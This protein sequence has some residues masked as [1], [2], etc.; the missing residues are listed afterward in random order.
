V[1]VE[2]PLSLHDDRQSLYVP[3]T[4]CN[5]DT[6]YIGEVLQA[7][8]IQLW[9]DDP[10]G[11]VHQF[12][13]A[14]REGG[15]EGGN[16]RSWS[17]QTPPDGFGDTAV[18]GEVLKFVP[19]LRVLQSNKIYLVGSDCAPFLVVGQPGLI[20]IKH[21]KYTSEHHVSQVIKS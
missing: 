3:N 4:P 15:R 18:G 17:G 11:C 21:C 14:K 5:S 9:V 19:S 12:F 10:V 2:T 8:S 1:F 6:W 20:T 16:L 7:Y 13:Q